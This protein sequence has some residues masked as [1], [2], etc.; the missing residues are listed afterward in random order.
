MRT[1][2][3]DDY[4]VKIDP[5]YVATDD[6]G[7]TYSVDIDETMLSANFHLEVVVQATEA[8]EPSIA[9][10]KGVLA[11]EKVVTAIMCTSFPSSSSSS[12]SSPLPLR[13]H[14]RQGRGV[15]MTCSIACPAL[16]AL[17][18]TGHLALSLLC[19][20]SISWQ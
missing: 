13:T 7:V 18:H 16:P 3:P 19:T 15:D 5:R 6:R 10:D 2:F 8:G 12:S 9:A 20:L 17:I 14:P 11:A 1:A 4:A